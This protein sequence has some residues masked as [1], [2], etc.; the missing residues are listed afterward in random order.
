MLERS[1]PGL[2]NN[3]MHPRRMDNVTCNSTSI[4]MELA[5]R[6]ERQRERQRQREREREEK[7][8]E[9]EGGKV[10]HFQSE[11][12]VQNGPAD[13]ASRKAVKVEGS[14]DARRGR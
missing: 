13:L 14:V 8:K 3:E 12:V 1:P 5:S 4:Q 6:E 9:E 7:E 11:N 2:S 10:V